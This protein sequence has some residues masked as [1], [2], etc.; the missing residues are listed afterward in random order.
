MEG[1][2]KFL[3]ERV[4]P[5]DPLEARKLRLKSLRYVLNGEHLYKRGYFRP[6]LRC[7][8]LV[9]AQCVLRT[10]HE[11]YCEGHPSARVFAGKILRQGYFWLTL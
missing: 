8:A 7:L 10:V 3:K 11:G 4:L 9:D 1:L 5:D 6:L 2:T